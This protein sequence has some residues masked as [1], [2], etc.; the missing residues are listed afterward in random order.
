MSTPG[1]DGAAAAS[2]VRVMT[3]NVW[4]R[5]ENWEERQA[6]LAAVLREQQPDIVLLQES[7]ADRHGRCQPEELAAALGGYHAAWPRDWKGNGS[8]FGNAIL[9]RWPVLH[10]ERHWLHR[11]DAGTPHRHVTLAV[12]DTPWGPWPAAS[13]HFEYPFDASAQR[14]LNAQELLHIVANRQ[15]DRAHAESILPVI[16]GADLNAVPDSDEVHLLTGRKPGV[17]GVVLSDVWEQVGP[18]GRLGAEGVTWNP[19]NPYLQHTAWPNRRLD[20]VLVSWPRRKPIGNPVRA[21]I[22]GDH[23]IEGV[24]PSDHFAVMAELYAGATAN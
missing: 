5:F 21:W 6:A 7:W 18:G 11:L 9:S 14:I 4:G 20:Y 22:A 3:W 2:S 17:R 16:V 8:W 1:T 23:P 15:G 24:F 12:L 10:T 13:T 19:R